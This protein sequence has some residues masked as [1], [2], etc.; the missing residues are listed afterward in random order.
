M[1]LPTEVS[2]LQNSIKHDKTC[3]GPGLVLPQ[4]Q[5]GPSSVVENM[6][7]FLLCLFVIFFLCDKHLYGL[8]GCR[9]LFDNEGIALSLIAFPGAVC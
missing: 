4:I 8:I 7:F 6:I 9:S 5:G 1:I 2:M 3:K